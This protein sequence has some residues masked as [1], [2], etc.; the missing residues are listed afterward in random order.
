[1]GG[2]GESG[3]SGIVRDVA[4]S[5]GAGPQT[6]APELE[7]REVELRAV[8]APAESGGEMPKVDTATADLIGH[9][10]SGESRLAHLSYRVR[11]E[12]T[13]GEDGPALLGGLGLR[14][15][16]VIQ[17]GEEYFFEGLP[18][19]QYRLNV[20]P[21]GIHWVMAEEHVLLGP[22]PNR[23][24]LRI[25]P[26]DPQR[27]LQVRCLDPA[28]KTIP[29]LVPFFHMRLSRGEMK[30]D[31][32]KC[33]P[34]MDGSKLVALPQGWPG[35]VPGSEGI[36]ALVLV[37]KHR[38]YGK[39][40]LVLRADQR[41]AVIQFSKPAE[42][43][44][45]ISNVPARLQGRLRA[46]VRALSLRGVTGPR[47]GMG[48]LP[49]EDGV[50]RYTK[51]EVGTNF[52]DVYVG[53]EVVGGTSSYTLVDTQLVEIAA[54]KQELTIPFPVLH[55]VAVRNPGGWPGREILLECV[56]GPDSL[57]LERP[58]SARLSADLR[59]DF[60]DCPAG[61]YLVR[62]GIL[63]LPVTVPCGE[64]VVRD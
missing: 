15:D 31:F 28:G 18:T 60:L 17:T 42:L 3:A 63:A 14:S 22:G 51:L 41:E 61:D 7:E 20:S 46:R 36:E 11:L 26:I 43:A 2:N 55:G 39:A 1:M 8:V 16:T 10:L 6:D 5:T 12:S 29:R 35:P 4:N 34:L 38:R 56:V 50:Y 24:D 19:G 25:D 37:A 52:V 40:S 45:R 44:L 32:P 49:G 53:T 23:V 62:C 21:V 27:S 54:G 64:V 58:R 48:P 13:D 30:D 59:L 9:L 47:H 57:C 33:L